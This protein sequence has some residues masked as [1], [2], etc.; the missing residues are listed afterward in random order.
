MASEPSADTDF[1][2]SLL[3]RRKQIY[4]KY[5]GFK[6]CKN[7]QSFLAVKLLNELLF[8]TQRCQGCLRA[9]YMV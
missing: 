9:K 7:R 2:V 8:S 3:T 1:W 4:K 6:K 5:L